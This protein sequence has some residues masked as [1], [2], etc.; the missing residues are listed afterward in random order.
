MWAG[1]ATAPVPIPEFTNP[2]LLARVQAI[3]DGFAKQ[4]QVPQQARAKF[5][6]LL[7]ADKGVAALEGGVLEVRRAFVCACVCV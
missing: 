2:Q 3:R 5:A 1:I 6:A 7:Q 4:M